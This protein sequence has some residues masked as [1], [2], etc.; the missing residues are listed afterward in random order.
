MLIVGRSASVLLDAVAMLRDRGYGANASNQFDTLLNDYDLG[1]VDLV[2]FG[3][4]VPPATK[5]RLRTDI[6]ELN[7]RVSFL[8]GLGGIAPLVVAQVEEYAGGAPSG[9]EYDPSARLFRIALGDAA[10]VKVEGLWAT[11]VPPEPVAQSVLI[12]DGELAA[13]VHQIAIPDDVPRQGSYATVR[14]GER[15]SALQIGETP[16]S[17]KRLAA[18]PLPAPRPVTTHYPWQ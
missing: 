11:F 15:V 16:R 18:Q 8:Q 1:E 6:H 3:G 17:V 5:E 9:V 12:L 4:M 10:P 13:G 14:I 7:P 2:V